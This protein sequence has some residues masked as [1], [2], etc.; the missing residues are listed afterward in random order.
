MT[1]R[2]VRPG[3]ID[4]PWESVTVPI[5]IEF[6][7]GYVFKNSDNPGRV[8]AV[9]LE[10]RYSNYTII[11]TDGSVDPVG[12]CVGCGFYVERDDFRYLVLPDSWRLNLCGSQSMW[13]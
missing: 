13:V 3:Y 6:T 7:S 2:S 4:L 10:Q 5:V 1:A 11:Y 8:F 9:F 12:G